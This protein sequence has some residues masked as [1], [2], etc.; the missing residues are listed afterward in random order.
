MWGKKKRRIADLEQRVRELVDERDEARAAA[1]VHL[2]AAVR[3]AGRNTVLAE[4]NERLAATDARHD[5]DIEQQTDRIERLLRACIR[6]RAQLATEAR[7]LR[8]LQGRLDH[9]LGLDSPAITAGADWQK[10]RQD[11]KEGSLT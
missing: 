6:Y 3:T 5:A 1:A 2:A 8:H 7:D 11:K 4:R 9:L 10:R